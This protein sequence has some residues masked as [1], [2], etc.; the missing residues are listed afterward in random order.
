MIE[1][2]EEFEVQDILAHRGKQPRIQYLVRFLNCG[3]EE[4]LWLPAGNLKNAPEIV[5][6]YWDRQEEVPLSPK[7]HSSQR[8]PRPLRRYGHIY[9]NHAGA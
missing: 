4:D 6:E 3:P 9:C 2:E 7:E 8:A 1:G 5:K